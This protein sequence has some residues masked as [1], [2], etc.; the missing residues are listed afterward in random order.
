MYEQ[1]L[2][3]REREILRDSR[4][5][6]SIYSPLTALAEAMSHR[7]ELVAPV[8][9]LD[10]YA[11]ALDVL[12]R[13]G[14]IV[15]RGQ[16]VG[17]IHESL[18]DYLHARAFVSERKPLVDFLLES[19]QTLFRRTQTRQIL[20]F[21]RELE[22]ARYISDLGAILSDTRVR[23]HIRE[24]IVRWLAT[25][26]DPMPTE[27][28]LVARYAECDGLPRKAGYVIF[29]RKPWFDL[30]QTLGVLDRWLLSEGDDLTWALGFLRSV[31][32]FAP[33][34]VA[35]LIDVFW[36]VGQTAF[37]MCSPCYV[38]SI[39]RPVRVAWRTL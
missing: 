18:F 2:R 4:A 37:A 22:R 23:P 25:I 29:E 5:G 7:Q 38:S 24:T 20:A 35:E 17:F 13:S 10:P 31:A 16:R 28:E 12:Q 6:W 36:S 30:L 33:E 11:A 9:T 19:E 3:I 21:E 34:E 26:P 32:P 39:P 27:W 8:S 15:V 14:L 1:L